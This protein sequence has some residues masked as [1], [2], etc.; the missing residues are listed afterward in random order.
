MCDDNRCSVGRYVLVL[1][2][3]GAILHSQE[4]GVD[5]NKAIFLPLLHSQG[6]PIKHLQQRVL[7]FTTNVPNVVTLEVDTARVLMLRDIHSTYTLHLGS[8]LAS[9]SYTD[10]YVVHMYLIYLSCKFS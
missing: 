3:V 7:I 9:Y 2:S 5:V 8:M 1:F 4:G 6:A 10:Y